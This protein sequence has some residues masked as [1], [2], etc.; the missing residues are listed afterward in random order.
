MEN[1]FE[2]DYVTTLPTVGNAPRVRIFG[3]TIDEYIVNIQSRDMVYNEN[4]KCKTNETLIPNLPQWYIEWIVRIYDSRGVM[5]Y[6]NDFKYHTANGVFFIKIDSV[7]LGDTLAWIPYVEEFR[8]KHKCTLICSTF[9]N[10]LFI[11]VYPNILFVKP[12]T[13]IDNISGQYYI[14]ATYDDNPYYCQI[15]A[16]YYPLQAFG[17]S[18]LGLDKRELKVNL[19]PQFSHINRLLEYDYVTISEFASSPIKL[20]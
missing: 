6:I 17:Y 4:Y 12:N 14:G 5:V 10:D 8:L 19:K 18:I 9:F 15:N 11:K 3:K 7:A 2:V 20:V 16:K 1:K 13:F